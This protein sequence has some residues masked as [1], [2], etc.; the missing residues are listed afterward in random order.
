MRA[1]WS[2]HFDPRSGRTIRQLTSGPANN[3]PLY[4]FIP[5]ITSDGRYLV[6]HSERGGWVQLY[7]LDLVSGEIVQLTDGRTRESGWA[8]WCEAHLRGIYNHVSALNVSRREVYYFQDEEVRCTHLDTLEN[9]VVHETPGRISIAQSAFSPDG[10]FF[11]FVHT[12]RELYGR[13]VADRESIINMGQP[14]SHERWREG[15]PCTIGL[16][17]TETGQYEDVYKTDFHIHHVLFLGSDRLL[18]NHTRGHN[19]IWTIDLKNDDIRELR[20]EGRGHACH[21][22]ITAAGIYYEANAYEDGKHVVWVGR[23]DPGTDTYD[24]V[25]LPD[26]VGYIHTGFDPEGRFL[27]YENQ[28]PSAD[29]HEI[30]TLHFPRDRSRYRL[31]ILKELP[32]VGHGQRNHAHPFLTPDRRSM[33]FTAKIDGFSQVC[34]LDVGDLVDCAEYW[35]DRPSP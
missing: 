28:G 8:V 25:T 33:I 6:F 7:R 24:E 11:A 4:Y 12:D 27:F 14:F 19:G 20:A 3:Y 30:F 16:I 23:Y 2:K 13:A 22:L 35:D 32:P 5:S 26:T 17:D 18:V 1:E 21:Q 15:I 34:A 31:D 29:R 9:R 10:Q